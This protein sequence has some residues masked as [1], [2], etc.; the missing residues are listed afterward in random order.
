MLM[1]LDS[2]VLPPSWNISAGCW[3]LSGYFYF[4]NF[5]VAISASKWLG[6]GTRYFYLLNVTDIMHIQ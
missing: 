4:L 6:P 1:D 2:N 3:S 5:A